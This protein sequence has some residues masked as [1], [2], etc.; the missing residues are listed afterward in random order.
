[1]KKI[2]FITYQELMIRLENSRPNHLLLG[3]GF[4][5]SLG[6]K[7]NYAEIFEKMKQAYS[8]YQD[9]EKYL[10]KECFDIEKLIGYLKEQVQ[11][12]EQDF[13]PGYIE[14]K[15]KLDF[16]KATN[17][18]VQENIKNVY[19]D[20]NQ[21]IYLLL[22][23]FTNYF[24]LNYDPFLYLLLLK[25]KK[26]EGN[27]GD[28]LVF[29]NTPLFQKEDLNQKQNNIYN[30]IEAMRKNG[31]LDIVN[32]DNRSSIDLR[33]INKTTFQRIV[34]EY[35]K[36]KKRG[37]EAK[38]IE[39]VCNQIWKE[40]N[41]QPE[42]SVNDGFLGEWFREDKS[43]NLY[44]LHG[45]FQILESKGS[46]KKITA[47]QNKSF[48]QKLEDAIHS[49]NEGVVC[50]LTNQSEAKKADIEKNKYLKKCFDDLSKIDG[51]LVIFGS[52]LSDNDGHIFNQV[53]ESPVKN[54]YISSCNNKKENDYQKARKIFKNKDIVL[55]DYETVSYSETEDEAI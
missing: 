6:I 40:E 46:I 37:W 48:V 10:K 14:R 8:S 11:S 49:E 32:G 26:D 51:A 42:L 53:I 1:M 41:N 22:K 9:V 27:S 28:A 29:Q 18:I 7:T 50:V 45:A 47:K 19:Q 13:L 16:M 17:E 44:F 55:F 4:N 3:N 43:Q 23:N 15:V 38:D 30:E 2:S 54:V 36:D 52:S 39:I 25:F 31:K 12:T 20:N 35:N 34:A 21:G 33:E 5:N 24:T